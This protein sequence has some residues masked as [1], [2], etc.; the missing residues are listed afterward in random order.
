MFLQYFQIN[1]NLRVV[2]AVSRG[3][4]GHLLT[5]AFVVKFCSYFW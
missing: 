5:H 1:R 2:C 3:D 4:D